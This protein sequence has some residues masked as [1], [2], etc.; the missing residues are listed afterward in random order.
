M[1]I[2]QKPR[3]FKNKSKYI[4]YNMEEKKE[5]KFYCEKCKY[6]TNVKHAM[7][8]HEIS[9]LHKT[10]KHGST[11]KIDFYRCNKCDYVHEHKYNYKTHMLNKHGTK[12]ERKE[13]FKYFC[14]KCDVG[15]FSKG[16]F[17]IHLDSKKHNRE[18]N[19]E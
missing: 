8:V 14:E 11:K 6:G 19:N 2:Y 13:T 16:I 12:E 18:I 3:L 7:K 1:N 15:T 4:N 17:D 5:Y 9:E 10:G